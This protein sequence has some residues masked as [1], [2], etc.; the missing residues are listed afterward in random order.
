LVETGVIG[1]GLDDES[2]GGDRDRV[3]PNMDMVEILRLRLGWRDEGI[4]N[5]W[6]VRLKLK[7]G[8]FLRVVDVIK[9]EVAE[10]DDCRGQYGKKR[11]GL[12]LCGG[13][14][15]GAWNDLLG[16]MSEKRLHGPQPV[17]ILY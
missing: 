9:V 8:R 7:V 12:S 11:E 5:A 3:R 4:E 13:Q 16:Y 2:A 1:R 10:M 6:D 15:S 17:C 14:T